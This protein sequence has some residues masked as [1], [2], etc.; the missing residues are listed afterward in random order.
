MEVRRAWNV[1]DHRLRREVGQGRAQ[2]VAESLH[3]AHLPHRRDSLREAGRLQPTVHA[4][5]GSPRQFVSPNNG[6]KSSTA[7]T[8]RRS[9][10]F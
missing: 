4:W 5:R 6:G 1:P 3:A 10:G 7:T 2:R 8:L 9:A